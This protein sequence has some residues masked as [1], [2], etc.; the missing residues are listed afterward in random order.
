MKW[1]WGT[2]LFIGAALFMIMLI[3]FGVLMM[4]ESIP[5]VERDYYPKGQEFQ[6]QIERRDNGLPYVDAVNVEV[7]DGQLL[8]VLPA[9]FL[10]E[11]LNGKL[12][13]YNRMDDTR[14][15][16]FE[17]AYHNDSVFVFEAGGLKGRY[18]AKITW[19]FGDREY[20]VEKSLLLP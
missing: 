17:F 19:S 6:K 11:G 1:N 2:K 12:Y 5:L 18:L 4:R 14:D 10:K 9:E 3:V 13:M 8:M 7:S 16:S 20:Y 15:A